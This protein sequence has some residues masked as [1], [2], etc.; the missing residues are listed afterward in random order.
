MTFQ[1]LGEL[2]MGKVES[3]KKRFISVVRGPAISLAPSIIKD[4]GM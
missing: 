2:V 4:A 3:S 1:K